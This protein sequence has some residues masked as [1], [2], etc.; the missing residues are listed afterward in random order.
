M[1]FIGFSKS[2]ELSSALRERATK[3]SFS[4]EPENLEK[5]LRGYNLALA[6]APPNSLECSLA[7]EK[8]A[9]LLLQL[10]EPNLAHEDI[11]ATSRIA[12]YPQQYRQKLISL[13]ARVTSASLTK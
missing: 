8:R 10:L 6:F 2:S 5:A 11:Q 4:N 9:E 12:S 7:L 3:W 1:H 13:Q